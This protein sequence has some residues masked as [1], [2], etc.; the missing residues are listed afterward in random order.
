MVIAFVCLATS[1]LE[2]E[3]PTTDL[4]S[5]ETSV[6]HSA[7]LDVHA[8]DDGDVK[9]DS[10]PGASAQKRK[11]KLRAKRPGQQRDAL[12]QEEMR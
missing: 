3:P 8:K 7:E 12:E 4:I 9:G 5:R 1:A 6:S 2:L 11:K 10:S